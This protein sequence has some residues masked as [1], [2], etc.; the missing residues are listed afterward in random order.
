[1]ARG[2]A[3]A[4]LT[5]LAVDLTVGAIATTG[6]PALSASSSVSNARRLSSPAPAMRMKRAPPNS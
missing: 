5:I 6:L 1:M 4:S 2:D 3:I